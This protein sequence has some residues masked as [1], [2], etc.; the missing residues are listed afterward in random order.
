M[1]ADFDLEEALAM[2]T[3]KSKASVYVR[4]QSGGRRP[5]GQRPGWDFSEYASFFQ[6]FLWLYRVAIA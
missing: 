5:G 1:S 2:R 3:W 6:V 4:M